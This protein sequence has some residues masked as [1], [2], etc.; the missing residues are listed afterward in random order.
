MS[1][2]QPFRRHWYQPHAG[3]DLTAPMRA[4]PPCVVEHALS[5]IARQSP[6]LDEEI[7]ALAEKVEWR[8]RG[9]LWQTRPL[10]GGLFFIPGGGKSGFSSAKSGI[11]SDGVASMIAFHD[12]REPCPRCGQVACE[13]RCP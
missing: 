5:R 2:F 6:R 13:G 12:L 7:I 10:P 4:N 9:D 8:V 3:N 1:D 11:I